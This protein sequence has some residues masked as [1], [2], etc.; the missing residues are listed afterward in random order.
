MLTHHLLVCKMYVGRGRGCVL[1]RPHAA[2]ASRSF[3]FWL[4]TSGQMVL[5]CFMNILDNGCC[6]VSQVPDFI[7]TGK[8]IILL[9]HNSE[10]NQFLLFSTRFLVRFSVT[11]IRWMP[12]RGWWSHLLGFTQNWSVF[13][14]SR[15]LPGL[16]A[17]VR[18]CLIFRIGVFWMLLNTFLYGLKSVVCHCACFLFSSKHWFTTNDLYQ[19]FL[20]FF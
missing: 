13:Y 5:A 1:I 15:L 20:G 7:L 8:K 10:E 14:C 12:L 18:L 2:G 16:K 9:G 19:C 17:D 6:L 3:A 11:L 4:S